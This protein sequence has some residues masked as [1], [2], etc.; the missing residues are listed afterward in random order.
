M[1]KDDLENW[2]KIKLHMETSGNTDNY[3][4]K[5]AVM[6][7]AGHDDPMENALTALTA[8]DTDSSE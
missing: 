3:Y 6:I 8:D 4:Y 2:E 5:R 7:L 1:S